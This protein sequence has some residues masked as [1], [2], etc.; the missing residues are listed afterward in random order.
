MEFSTIGN[1]V[2]IAKGKKHSSLFDS[3]NGNTKRYIQIEDLRNDFNLKYTDEIGIDV[4]P[5][6]VVIAWD[7]ANAGTIGFNLHG[8]IGST[9]ARLRINS[10]KI[11]SKYLGWLLKGKFNYLRSQC[12]GATIPHISKSVLE[13]ISV[14]I[15]PIKTQQKIASILEQADAARQKRKQ[16]SQLT[17]QFLQSAFL[18]MFEDPASNV[19]GF[20][21]RELKDI[22]R[23]D[24]KVNY[25]VVQP[26]DD[27]PNGI[28]LIRVGD[29]DGMKISKVNLKRISPTI[30][31]QYKRSRI[32]GDEIF[33]A[34]VGSI[35]K[36]ALSDESLKGFNTVRAV[37][38]IRC[39]E[40]VN[41]VYLAYYFTTPFIQNYFINQTRTVSQ[42]TLNIK[43]IEETKIILPPLLLQQKFTSVV[44]QVEQ[45][46]VKQRESEKALENLFQS[47]MQKY[48]N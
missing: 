19:S 48:F 18:E 6:D 39:S 46:R 31:S 21:I 14:P 32:I 17:E 4:N 24:D 47:L 34:C 25:G 22:V 16:A 2:S 43:Q 42:P 10:R 33:V 9:L 29:I 44:N 36:V 23:K 7:G 30:E 11:N 13:N 26:G 45:L 12:T 3:P 28:P 8:Y 5:N 1:I 20:E 40:K 35:G 37:A 41:R 15:P 27:V 38:R